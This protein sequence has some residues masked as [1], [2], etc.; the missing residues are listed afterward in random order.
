MTE[1]ECKKQLREVSMMI[2]DGIA[3]MTDEQRKHFEE[4]L[5]KFTK[6]NGVV[7]IG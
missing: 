2:P 3:R 1:A 6:S 5:Y 7:S 4:S